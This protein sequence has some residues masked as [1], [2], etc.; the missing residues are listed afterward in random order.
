MKPHFSREQDEANMRLRHA[1]ARL[2][3]LR[4]RLRRRGHKPDEAYWKTQLA[5]FW[6]QV[7]IDQ[8]IARGE[9]S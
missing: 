7:R 6:Q 8:R 5:S 1:G 4:K 3:Q 2:E 9:L